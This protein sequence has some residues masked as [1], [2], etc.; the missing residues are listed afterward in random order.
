LNAAAA[1]LE[2]YWAKANIETGNSDPLP[3]RCKEMPRFMNND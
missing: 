3:N 2:H 1:A